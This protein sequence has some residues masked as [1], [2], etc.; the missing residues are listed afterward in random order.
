MKRKLNF[1]LVPDGCWYSNLRSMLS[2]KD[3][4]MIKKDA[5]VRSGGECTICGKKTDKL[6]AHEVWSYDIEKGIQKLE[7]VISVCKDCHSVIHIGYT[8]L[9]G[10]IERAEQHYLKVNNC[11]YAEYRQDLNKANL[12]HKER[13]KVSEWKLDLTW[14]KRYLDN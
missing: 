4:N 7:N 5:K 9:K 2:P 11:T 8:Q 14:L 3:W 12:L 1:E 13:N 6:D 10:N